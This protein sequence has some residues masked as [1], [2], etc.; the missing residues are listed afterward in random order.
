[1][2][3]KGPMHCSG[4]GNDMLWNDGEEDGGVRDEC[5]ED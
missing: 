1:M 4:I 3:V 5:E 2:T